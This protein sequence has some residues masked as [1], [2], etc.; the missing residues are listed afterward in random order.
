MCDCVREIESRLKI[1][2]SIS[3]YLSLNDWAMWEEY[4]KKDSIKKVSKEFRKQIL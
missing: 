4:E 2:L 3:L 1:H